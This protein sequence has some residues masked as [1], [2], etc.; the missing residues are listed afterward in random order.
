MRPGRS[1]G[2]TGPAAPL[3]AQLAA[4]GIEVLDVPAKLARRVRM[5]STGHGRKTDQ[6]DALSVGIAVIDEA[7]AALRPLTGTVMIWSAPGHRPPAGCTSC[8]P[9]SFLLACPAG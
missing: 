9:S 6:A 4:E 3:T 1:R 5:L 2:A 8:W 7:T